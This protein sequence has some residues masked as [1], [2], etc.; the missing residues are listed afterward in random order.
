MR[1]KKRSNGLCENCRGGIV[2]DRIAV[3]SRK[4]ERMSA[5]RLLKT[6]H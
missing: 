1:L 6:L 5:R 4:I 2:R 3:E